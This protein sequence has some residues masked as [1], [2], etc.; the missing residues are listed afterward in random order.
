MPA[1]FLC[2]TSRAEH[3]VYPSRSVYSTGCHGGDDCLRIDTSF[4]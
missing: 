4:T 1:P 3:D 2:S